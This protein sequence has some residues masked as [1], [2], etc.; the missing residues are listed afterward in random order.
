M[1]YKISA[2]IPTYNRKNVISRAIDSALNQTYPMHEIIVVDDGSTDGTEDF[3]KKK[4]GKKIRYFKQKNQGPSAAR[5]L[6]IKKSTGD[7]IA[8]LDSDDEWLPKKTEKQ[9]NAMEQDIN[10]GINSSDAYTAN[11]E[12]YNGK[13][14]VNKGNHT[15]RRL[16]RPL[17]I[18][19]TKNFVPTSTVLAKKTELQ[20]AGLFD[21]RYNLSEDYKL[22]CYIALKNSFIYV[23]E[24][25]I[26]QHET[27]GSLRS[28]KIGIHK[29][30]IEILDNIRSKERIPVLLNLKI[31]MA[32]HERYK[33]IGN[34]LYDEQRYQNAFF[35]YRKAFIS[36]IKQ[37]RTL[38]RMT[39]CFIRRMT[40]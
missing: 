32:I 12:R 21:L 30:A 24:A 18:L 29:S 6:G 9:T 8:F 20:D 28:D 33:K 38:L 1:T 39:Y 11:K 27:K 17:A 10:I 37:P 16:D 31:K 36:T 19:L 34:A 26:I 5:N 2:I 13:G 35:F 40:R 23:S 15:I 25:L 7:W 4:Y 14:R 3:L 22:W